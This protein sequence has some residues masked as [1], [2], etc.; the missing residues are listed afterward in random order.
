MEGRR[1]QIRI[2]GAGRQCA[3][4]RIEHVGIAVL[5]IGVTLVLV[6]P[7]SYVNGH[8]LPDAIPCRVNIQVPD[9]FRW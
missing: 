5:A 4:T 6:P 3:V 8:Q 9:S 2:I 1:A 7:L